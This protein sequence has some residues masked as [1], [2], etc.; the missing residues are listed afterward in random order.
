MG[1]KTITLIA[2]V[3]RNGAIGAD[4]LN[5]WDIPEDLEA[6]RKETAGGALIM[7]RH[8]WERLPRQPIAGRYNIVV[9]SHPLPELHDEV[10]VV[11]SVEEAIERACAVADRIYGIGGQGIYEAL[12]DH[13]D[14]LLI[15]SVNSVVKGGHSVFPDF[16]LDGW[17]E[18][19]IE[20]LRM[21]DPSCT[22]IEF[23]RQEALA[24]A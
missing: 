24:L 5:P 13:A 1:R 15:S 3:S 16:D 10:I 2:T 22:R 4:G 9:T 7:G 18:M 21:E 12:I 19:A 11:S 23:I 8:T 14:R 17:E 20:E 6:F